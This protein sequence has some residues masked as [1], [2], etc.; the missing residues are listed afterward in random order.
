M[1]SDP[2]KPQAQTGDA[3]DL[4]FA[5]LHAIKDRQACRRDVSNLRQFGACSAEEQSVVAAEDA[6][7]G[8]RTVSP[9]FLRVCRQFELQHHARPSWT[10]KISA[11]LS[12]SN[13]GGVSLPSALNVR[14][15]PRYLLNDEAT[16]TGTG[17]P[18]GKVERI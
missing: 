1:A 4:S 16:V 6:K 2:P 7:H 12:K 15:R 13:C 18:W 3:L 14:S 17:V 5:K 10:A 11:L 9:T 8:R